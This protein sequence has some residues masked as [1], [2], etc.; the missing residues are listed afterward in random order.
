MSF[1]QNYDFALSILIHLS[2]RFIESPQI[3]QNIVHY[4]ICV[5]LPI[6]MCSCART[7]RAADEYKL[8]TNYKISRESFGIT[9]VKRENRRF[10]RSEFLS[11]FGSKRSNL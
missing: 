11:E 1:E 6:T 8:L 9:G 3:N 2:I 4:V 5:C 7:N 10:E